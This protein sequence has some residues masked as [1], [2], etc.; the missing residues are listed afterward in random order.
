MENI[1]KIKNN[2]GILTIYLDEKLNK[3]DVFHGES[4]FGKF[5]NLRF[6]IHKNNERKL[7]TFYDDRQGSLPHNIYLMIEDYEGFSF[8]KGHF[9]ESETEHDINEFDTID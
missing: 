7:Y 1:I 8:Y 9:N 3:Y 2:S 6:E 5:E 4:G